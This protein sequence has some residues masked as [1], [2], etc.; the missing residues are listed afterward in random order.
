MAVL[1]T[2]YKVLGRIAPATANTLS[3]LY[4]VPSNTSAVVSTLS[5]CNQTASAGTYTVAIRPGGA[6]IAP[7]HY[8]AYNATVA[9]QDTIALTIGISLA[10][11]DIV[12][13]SASNTFTSFNLFGSEI[14]TTTPSAPT[15]LEYLIVGGGGGGGYDFGGGAGGGGLLTGA[16]SISSSTTYTVTVG[17]GGSAGASSTNGG[18]GQVSSFSTPTDVTYSGVFNGTNTYI[19]KA[20]AG[21]LTTVGGDLTIE[22]WVYSNTSSIT[23]LYDGG[24]GETN[25]VRNIT[26]NKF[27]YQGNDAAGAD[28]TGKF[29]VSSWFHL[30]ITYSGSG[31]IVKAYVN[32]ILA[33]T[34][35]AGS[36]AVGSNFDIGSINGNSAYFNGY[37]SNFRVTNRL[38]YG[39][40]F[41]PPVNPIS[42]VTNTSYLVLKNATFIDNSINNYT[43]TTPGSAPT[44]SSSVTPP[45][46]ITAFGGGG[47]RSFQATIAADNNGGSGGGARGNGANTEYGSGTVGQGYAGGA[48]STGAGGGG[49]AGA[50]GT[51]GTSSAGG[52]GGVGLISYILGGSTYYAG[53]GGGGGYTSSGVP[54]AGAGGTGGGGGGAV[55]G[56]GTSGTINTGG[57]GGGGA[58][59]AGAGGVGGSGI[60]ILRY[61]S[62]GYSAATSTVGS[63]TY[64]IVGGYKTYT[65]T[66]SGSITF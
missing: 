13:V 52:A 48:A 60:V 3:T 25:I 40:N 49:G 54:T 51:A 43:I 10:Q 66:S 63:P 21:V 16:V 62:Y 23:G 36:Y 12:S 7:K 8:I 27:G 19:R 1:S 5:I 2:T 26:A 35:S 42:T 17:S 9:A 22:A 38:V 24:P 50:V 15:S 57:G 11:T 29:P 56:A 46:G 34:G 64:T 45:I 41:M 53:G 14:A 44:I 20:G 32:G 61:P 37:L 4:T 18:K 33:A 30:A 28:I 65:F 55:S 31:S 6:T 58:G 47:G 59:S 39:A